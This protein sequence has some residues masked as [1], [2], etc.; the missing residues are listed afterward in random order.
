MSNEHEEFASSRSP[1]RKFAESMEHGDNVPGPPPGPPPAYSPPSNKQFS[2]DN[3]RSSIARFPSPPT[4][5]AVDERGAQG[6][7][8]TATQSSEKAGEGA[9][10][11]MEMQT[12]GNVP[13]LISTMSMDSKGKQD[14]AMD[15]D[16]LGSP[17]LEKQ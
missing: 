16:D 1:K 7:E 11:M 17:G 2:G 3:E 5:S 9:R 12:K 13:R 4:Y 8:I 15:V 14:D 10:E 6:K